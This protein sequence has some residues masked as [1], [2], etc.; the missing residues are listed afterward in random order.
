MTVLV[1]VASVGKELVVAWRFG[2][3]DELDAFFI[4]W[5]VPSLLIVVLADSFN[6]ALIPVF[7]RLRELEGK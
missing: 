3:G 7:V 2:T 6:G 1:K 5:L 4:A